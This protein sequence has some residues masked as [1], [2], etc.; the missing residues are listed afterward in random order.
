MTAAPPRL[1]LLALVVLLTGCPAA[2]DDEFADDD[3]AGDDDTAEVTDLLDVQPAELHFGYVELG[4]TATGTLALTNVA[5]D[6]AYLEDIFV[7]GDAS[8]V[9]LDTDIERILVPE[10]YTD[11]P[12]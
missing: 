8:F 12:V 4:T 6:T 3:T 2:D 5:E 7:E 10:A 1:L 11:L 9:V